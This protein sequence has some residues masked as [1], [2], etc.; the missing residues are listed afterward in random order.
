MLV[1]I[2]DTAA[3]FDLEKQLQQVREMQLRAA[4]EGRRM[5]ASELQEAEARAIDEVKQKY[6]C[7]VARLAFMPPAQADAVTDQQDYEGRQYKDGEFPIFDAH[8]RILSLPSVGDPR[9]DD[10]DPPTPAADPR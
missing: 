2:R 6:Y 9:H 3:L 5:E 4:R 8:H 10:P 1:I 7:Q